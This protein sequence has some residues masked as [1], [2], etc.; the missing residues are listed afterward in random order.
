MSLLNIGV[1]QLTISLLY[2]YGKLR[3][4]FMCELCTAQ[5]NIAFVRCVESKHCRRRA[6]SIRVEFGI[7]GDLKMEQGLQNQR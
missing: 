5:A 1:C 2:F 6:L 7:K 3:Q 4:D